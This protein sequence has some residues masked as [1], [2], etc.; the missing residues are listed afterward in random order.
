MFSNL[1]NWQQERN[2][3]FGYS[4]TFPSRSN[5]NSRRERRWD[6]P[7]RRRDFSF[8]SAFLSCCLL[9]SS[10]PVMIPSSR[11]P[12]LVGSR[13]RWCGRI[14]SRTILILEFFHGCHR[15]VKGRKKHLEIVWSSTPRGGRRVLGVPWV[16]R[17]QRK[18]HFLF[19][20]CSV[21]VLA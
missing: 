13:R 18:T 1:V 8:C 16:V 17:Q 15:S 21:G 12:Q 6:P 3:I 11:H 2:I 9:K 4:G 14:R 7:H 5:S 19:A 10:V 20:F